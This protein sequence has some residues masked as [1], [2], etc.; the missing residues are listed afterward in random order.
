MGRRHDELKGPH[1]VRHGEP[2]PRVGEGP[3]QPAGG[4]N[5]QLVDA[6]AAADAPGEDR[7]DD[8]VEL[9]IVPRRDVLP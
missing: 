6:G 5:L 4:A 2:E 9:S 8:G 3:L 7:A 1:D